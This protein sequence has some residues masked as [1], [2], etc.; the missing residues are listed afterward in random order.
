MLFSLWIF[1]PA[2]MG[3]GP[4]SP[5]TILA[6]RGGARSPDAREPGIIAVRWSS[7]NARGHAGWGPVGRWYPPDRFALEHHA[8]RSLPGAYPHPSQDK[9]PGLLPQPTFSPENARL[10]K[11]L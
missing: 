6:G 10:G 4:D 3:G 9:K 5:P 1:G 8:H 7:S 11:E 2:R